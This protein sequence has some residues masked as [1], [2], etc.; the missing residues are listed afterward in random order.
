MR[1]EKLARLLN[2]LTQRPAEPVRADLAEDIKQQIPQQLIPHSAADTISIIIDLRVSK[3]A[4]AAVI[5][6][7]MVLCAHFFGSINSTG[8]GIYQDGGML[9]RY[10]LGDVGKSG[11]QA[12]A[13]RFYEY[14]VH[15]GREVVYYADSIG[16]A[17][18]N[19]VL[20]HW[21]LPNGRYGVVFGDL[22][23]REVSA[24]ELIKLQAR[25]LQKK[26]R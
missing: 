13:S 20:I 22:H 17:D 1:N 24:E 21:K 3:L 5:I 4:V 26:T 18:S 12:G 6:I 23:E 16:P 8:G 15:Q 9:V 25:M 19:A 14:L 7:T 2:E 11:M 10:F